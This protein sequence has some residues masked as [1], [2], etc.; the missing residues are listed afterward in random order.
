MLKVVRAE[1]MI[2]EERMLS[3]S[4]EVEYKVMDSRRFTHGREY[5]EALQSKAL[6]PAFMNTQVKVSSTLIPRFMQALP[7]N[8]HYRLKN[9][10]VQHQG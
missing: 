1:F 5:Y 9:A 8:R 10:H 3:K 6:E 2:K 4:R 7:L